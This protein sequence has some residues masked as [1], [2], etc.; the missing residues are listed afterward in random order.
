M[1]DYVEYNPP[2]DGVSPRG[3]QAGMA[4]EN[5]TRNYKDATQPIRWWKDETYHVPPA[6]L[7]YQTVPYEGE[8]GADIA[9][10]G[11]PDWL[12]YRQAFSLKDCGDFIGLDVIRSGWLWHKGV[13]SI[14]LPASHGYYADNPEYGRIHTDGSRSGGQPPKDSTPIFSVEAWQAETKANLPAIEA[15]G[16]SV[17]FAPDWAAAL[18]WSTTDLHSTYAIELIRSSVRPVL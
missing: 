6:A 4:W 3:W 18:Y 15:A 17:T 1:T 5:N 9:V 11:R 10:N 12:P 8:W 16:H 13:T 2:A 7:H 14:R